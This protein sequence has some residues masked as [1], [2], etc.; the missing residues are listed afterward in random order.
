MVRSEFNNVQLTGIAAA[1]PNRW[2]SFKHQIPDFEKYNKVTG[3]KGRYEVGTLQT[4]SDLAYAAAEK[5]IR[6][7][8][9]ERETIGAIIFV[10]Q[11]A[12]Y[13]TP[14]TACVLQHRL[15]LSENCLAFDVAL[16]CSGYIYGLQ[17][18]ASLV[19]T[20]NIQRALLLTGVTPSKK[21]PNSKSNSDQYLFG[22]AGAATLLEKN[23]A[24]EKLIFGL[25]T[26]G[27]GY[28]LI[29]N[30]YGHWRHPGKPLQATM[31]GIEVFKF[32]I[33]RVPQI[34]NE[35]FIKEEKS[36]DDYDYLI[37][38]QANLMILKQIT[39]KTGFSA[40]KNLISLD[41]FA[42]TNSVSIPLTLVKHFGAL[43]NN[44]IISCLASGFG[45]GLSWGIA[46]IKLNTKDI[47][48]LIRT[49]EFFDDKL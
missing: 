5:I 21:K 33:S 23:Q 26:D 27:S 37:L 2:V 43:E 44:R 4:A 39:K 48:P 45:I 22:D 15:N 16:G 46:S 40:E 3:I 19:Q 10:T 18:V 28:Q 36:A 8:N 38:H 1:I 47:F 35:F 12:D 42:N 49:D 11:Q 9:V 34:I 30:P 25:K 20:S 14:A 7:K 31:D 6:E 41:E 17:L 29:M 13:F 24:E 32:S